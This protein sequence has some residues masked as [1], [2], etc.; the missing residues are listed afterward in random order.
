M[1]WSVWLLALLC[2]VELCPAD[3]KKDVLN[4]AKRLAEKP[5]Y[6]WRATTKIED[7]ASNWRPGPVEGKAEKGGFIHFVSSFGD[8]NYE[9]AIKGDRQALKRDGQWQSSEELPS[10]QEWIA[11]RLKAFKAPPAEA[12]D[13]AAKT[14]ELKKGDGGVYS[15]DLTDAGIKEI[16]ARGRRTASDPRNTKGW[17]KF[18]IKDGALIKYEYNLQGTITVGDDGREIEVNRTTTVEVK[19]LGSTKLTLPEEAK[20]KLS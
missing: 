6:S 15:G 3:D 12:E 19:D 13:L 2:L 8:N 1:R 5:N 9:V 17:A 18:W 11:R 20:K 4:A 7:G 16:F 14:R 10:D